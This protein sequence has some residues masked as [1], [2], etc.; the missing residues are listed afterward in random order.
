MASAVPRKRSLVTTESV[1]PFRRPRLQRLLEEATE[2]AVTVITAPAGYGKTIAVEHFLDSPGSRGGRVQCLGRDDRRSAW[3]KIFVGLRAAGVDPRTVERL[4]RLTA[5]ADHDSSTVRLEMLEV[6]AALDRPTIV[7]LDGLEQ[8]HDASVYPELAFLVNRIPGPLRLILVSRQQIPLPLPRWRA[9]GHLTE[10]GP[11]DL[12]FDLDEAVAFVEAS[13]AGEQRRQDVEALNSRAEGWPAGLAFLV[14]AGGDSGPRPDFDPERASRLVDHL[15]GGLPE[16]L[17]DF[18]RRTSI[19]R[20]LSGDLCQAVTGLDDAGRLLR[21]VEQR[22]LFL[23]PVDP[24][25]SWFRYQ[26]LFGELMRWEL[27]RRDP[28]AHDVG[29]RRAAAWYTEAGDRQ[30][31]VGHLIAAGQAE[32]AF[33]LASI[34]A[35][36]PGREDAIL[37]TD[38]STMFPLEWVEDDPARMVNY[39]VLLGQSGWLAEASAWIDRAEAA[40]AGWPDD[41][42][43]HGLLSGARA[44]WY[45]LNLDVRRVAE[46]GERALELFGS[47]PGF[48]P[49]RQRVAVALVNAGLVMDDVAAA[50]RNIAV[51]R[52]VRGSSIAQDLVVPGLEAR[53]AY[54]VGE[55]RRAEA[56]ARRVMWTAKA[57]DRRRHG[58]VRD[59]DRVLGGIAAEHGDLVGAE[60]HLRGAVQSAV[61]QGWPVIAAYIQLDL[62]PVRAA[63]GGPTA[64]LAALEEAR[65]LA[66]QGLPGPQFLA[67]LDAAEAR[68][69]LALGEVD[70]AE[71]LVERS[72][73]G[74]ER[75]LLEVR[76]ALA[77]QD[78]DR[79][80]ALLT[81][82][83]SQHRRDRIV[84]HLLAA[85]LAAAAGRAGERD[86]ELLVAAGLATP[87]RCGRIVVDEAPD[88]VERLRQLADEHRDLSP[89]LA[90]IEAFGDAA[91]PG[92]GADVLT[93]RESSV[94]RY[95]MSSLTISE[96]AGELD[97]SVNTLKT[98]VRSLYRKLGARSRPEA[99]AAGR[100]AGLL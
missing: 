30:A 17:Q 68:L 9:Q 2:R 28:R 36:L 37:G 1:V 100:R 48:D 72:P 93:E 43:R 87:E 3:R 26:R 20:R 10:I 13:S 35:S 15:I 60:Q 6:L 54:R 25:R 7:V 58:A 66:A 41:D 94:L 50:E 42:P 78:L 8:V 27:G 73:P 53:L 14:A 46:S 74:V 29:H 32:E 24:S 44:A 65:D 19:L 86:R 70:R 96:I 77:H 97:I 23:V 57:M 18:V 88:L 33:K 5:Q 39:A 69:R 82:V 84:V 98:H 62:V 64:G 11:D 45:G 52:E 47:D 22:N 90:A 79:A 76:L 61:E 34:D 99:V 92:P 75:Q 21:Q 38:W 81:S 16:D 51:L 31:A 91:A 89:L 12:R 49:L 95:L 55:L 59:A 83:T 40:L 56:L 63:S 80:H 67:R 85:R 71:A 4:D